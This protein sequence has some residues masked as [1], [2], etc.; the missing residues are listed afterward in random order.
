[1]TTGEILRYA[2]ND[3]AGRS[4]VFLVRTP[5]VRTLDH[6]CRYDLAILVAKRVAP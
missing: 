6:K 5:S 2:Q 3:K 4:R 1:M